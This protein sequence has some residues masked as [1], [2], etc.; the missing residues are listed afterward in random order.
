MALKSPRQTGGQPRWRLSIRHAV[1][2]MIVVIVVVGGVGYFALNATT[3]SY[4]TGITRCSPASAPKCVG[5]SASHDVTLF[6]PYTPGFSQNLLQISQGQNLPATVGVTGPES[7]NSYSVNWG[8][9]TTTTAVSPTSTHS[10]SSLGTFILSA[11]A[12]VG[13]T[14]H[15]GPEQLYPVEVTPSFED[16]EL[17]YYPTITASLTN[18]SASTGYQFGWLEGSGSVKVLAS[19][20]GE[21][22]NPSFTSGNLAL[23]SSGGVQ[24]NLVLN[25]TS[26]SATYT[27]SNTGGMIA[28]NTITLVVPINGPTPG[29]YA[30][31]TWTVVVTPAGVPPGCDRCQTSA[32]TSPHPG[33]I[34]N[35]EVAPGGAESLDPSVDY[36]TVGFEV[37]LN[38]YQ[39]LINYNGSATGPGYSS[40]VPQAATC[41]PGS[42]Q[43]AALYGGATLQSGNYFTF[44]INPSSKF[45]DPTTTKSWPVYPS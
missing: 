5:T 34:D 13:S 6:V 36:D 8:D 33:T 27:F 2:I 23:I 3:G 21:P 40:Y 42:S 19:I 37:I 18:G 28:V 15:N 12:L 39:T 20:S 25:A 17:G 31:Y 32:V 14:L 29:L 45:Y 38:V 35:Y 44:V 26:A 43:C 7:V 16:D 24:S 4:A 9:G 1:V 11:Y 30:N 10:F 41:V 22:L